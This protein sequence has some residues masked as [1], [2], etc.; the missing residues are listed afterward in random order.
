M[1]D[2]RV[3]NWRYTV[4]AQRRRL[5]LLPVGDERIANAVVPER[6]EGGLEL[7][8]SGDPYAT[9]A[10]PDLSAWALATSDTPAALL[11]RLARAVEPAGWLLASAAQDSITSPSLNLIGLH[12]R[13]L[14]KTR[15]AVLTMNCVRK[16]SMRLQSGHKLQFILC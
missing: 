6:N 14:R 16:S 12:A 7:A 8:L 11:H 4:P 9:V 5:L 1:I 3:L 2:A 13:P 15:N 10:A